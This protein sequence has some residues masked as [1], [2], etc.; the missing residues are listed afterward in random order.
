MMN[1]SFYYYYQTTAGNTL[2]EEENIYMVKI[3]KFY[4]NGVLK[5]ML[6]KLN[7]LIYWFDF[8]P[9]GQVCS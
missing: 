3:I 6:A 1:V 2:E 8:Y 9:W 4:L 7:G 5:N